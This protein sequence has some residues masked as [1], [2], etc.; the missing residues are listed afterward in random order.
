MTLGGVVVLVVMES[1]LKVEFV[2]VFTYPCTV[3][4]LVVMESDLKD[5][6]V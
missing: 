6:N 3:V 1:D 4:V 2:K 5:G